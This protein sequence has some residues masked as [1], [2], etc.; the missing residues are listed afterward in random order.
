[1]TQSSYVL[2]KRP[3][4]RLA[5]LALL[6]ACV[7]GCYSPP[8]SDGA[9]GRQFSHDSTEYQR[10]IVMLA[11][12]SS[13]GTIGPGF[14]WRADKPFE[15]A[16][17]A[18]VGITEARLVEYKQVLA[19]LGV[20]RLDRHGRGRVVFGIWGSGFGGHTH[21]KG[22]AWMGDPPTAGGFR[23]FREIHAPWYIY[24]D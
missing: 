20:A 19:Y 22:I 17:V 9:L 7:A 12:D 11:T 16:T 10:I 14:L 8:P 13:L 24:Q 21:H 23:R 5:T 18:E 4:R 1:M 6:V 3:R 15:D 2:A